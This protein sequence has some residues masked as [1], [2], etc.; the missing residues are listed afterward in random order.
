MYSQVPA[1]STGDRGML[2]LLTLDRNGRLVILSSRP[3]KTCICPCRRW[4]T[5]FACAL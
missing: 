5:G 4:T 1:L 3:T 2:D